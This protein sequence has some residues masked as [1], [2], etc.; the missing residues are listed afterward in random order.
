MCST[1]FTRFAILSV[2]A[3]AAAGQPSIPLTVPAGFPLR[4]YLTRRAPKKVGEP[5][6][7]KL[8]EPVFAF[9]REVVPAG[10]EVSGRV[11]RLTP[12]PRTQRAASMLAGDF[13]PLHNAQVV[14]TS[15]LLPDGR[16]MEL[17]TRETAGLN[18][19]YEPPRP[20]K[21]RKHDRGAQKGGVLGTA[22]NEAQ[23]RI[24]AAVNARTHG[25]ADIVRGPNKKEKLFDFLIA[26]LPY[27]PQW[28]RK[29]ARFDAELD[30]ALNFGALRPKPE[31]LQ[32]VG[33]QPPADGIV[34]TRLA[35]ALSSASAQPGDRVK[36][37]VSQPLFSPNA[38]LILPAGACL[39]GKVTVAHRAR[40]FHRGGQLRFNF[41]Q[42][43]LPDEVRQY[44]ASQPPAQLKTVATLSAAEG[45]GASAIKVDEEG[46]VKA[47]ESKA[48][49]IRPAIALV[50]ASR[51]MDNDTGRARAA[52]SADG[53]VG[54]R[55]LGG[56]SGFG[57]LGAFAAQSSP[58]VA[59][60]LGMYGLAWSVYSTVISRGGEVEFAKNA[61]LDIRFGARAP[62][63][64]AKFARAF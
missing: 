32:L 52:G 4:V 2:V 43:E 21:R 3:T 62:A 28:I 27:H 17:S 56:I 1:C 48:R 10:A 5:V 25:V 19:I 15:L 57:L 14:F 38:R 61:A 41:Q 31:T 42:I 54:G 37:V 7:A 58:G 26:R 47:V 34:H 23:N 55:T 64:A 16:R 24:N 11:I 59:S 45:S 60:A 12:A 50:V 20:P 40:W 51:A 49:L 46:G 36:A 29:G 9:D 63:A 44:M 35:M 6:H 22:K 39:M 30:R 53:N 13:T 33:T 8:L 18:S